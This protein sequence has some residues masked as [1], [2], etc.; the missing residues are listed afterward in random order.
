MTEMDLYIKK[1][2]EAHPLRKDILRS[3]IAELK[4]PQGTRGL[5]AGCGIGQP[6]ML[7][8]ET[9]G[10][11]GHVTGLDISPELLHHGEK[12]VKNSGLSDRITFQKGDVGKL[13]FKD[14]TFDWVWSS[15]CVGYP[16]GELLPQLKELAR[17][18]KSGGT[19]AILA[20]SSQQLLPGYPLL[21][22]RL[23]AASSSYFPYVLGA[24]PESN[25][26]RALGWFRQAGFK[27]SKAKTYVGDV[28]APL[29]DDNR[30]ALLAF[31]EMLWG[32]PQPDESPGDRAEYLR[33]CRPESEDFI[34]NLPDYYAFFTCSMFWGKVP[35]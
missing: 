22:A 29:A 1:L 31:F 35:V 7:L 3:A 28:S 23:N 26:V 15:D 11:E 8:A 32:K 5:D 2:E 34:L 20:W 6:A 12:I 9:V 10:P 19:V 21:E 13:P 24:K 33:L 16:V 14:N 25:F 30:T 4:L 27:N 18:T 17:V